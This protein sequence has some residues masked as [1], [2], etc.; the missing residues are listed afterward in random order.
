M[1]D[2][3]LRFRKTPSGIVVWSPPSKK[4]MKLL[5]TVQRIATKLVP[6]I[7]NWKCEDCLAVLNLTSLQERRARGDMIQQFKL[8][9]GINEVSWVNPQVHS[10]S[11]SQASTKSMQRANSFTNRV[12]NEW[13]ALPA[14][15]TDSDSVNQFKNRYD[16]YKTGRQVFV[17]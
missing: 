7:K 5:E 4:N 14:A 8:T 1:Q 13:N 6:R 12:V 17:S 3:L 9:N 15:V 11:L 2:P 16:A 10:S